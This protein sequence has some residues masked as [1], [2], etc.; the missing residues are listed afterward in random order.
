[1]IVNFNHVPKEWKKIKISEKLFFQEGPGVRKWQ[2]AKKGIKLLNV[3]NI[4]KGVVDLS[5]TD[6]NLSIEEATGKYSHFLVDEGDLLIACSGIVVDNFHNKIAFAKKEDLP[7]CLNTST[8]RFKPLNGDIDLN[9]FKYFLQTVHFSSQLQKLITGSAQ[10]NFGPSHIKKIDFL[11]PHLKIQQHI[12]GILDDAAA[13][14]DKTAQ[15]LIEYDLLAQSVF[16]EM[17]GD[18]VINEKGW[19]VKKLDNLTNLITDGKHGNCNDEDNSGYFFISAKDVKN[20]KI[21][22]L[23]TRQI[24]KKEFEEVDRRTNLQAGDLVMINTGATIGRMAIAVDIPETRKTTFQK[25]VA[26]IKTKKEVLIPLYLQYVFELRLDTF[27]NKGSGSAIKN[28]LLSEMKRF[29]IIVPPIE[30]QNE[31][32]DKIALIEQ[33]KVLAKQELQESEDLFNCLLQQAFKGELV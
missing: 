4:N 22:Y 17:F 5:T 23:N 31:F 33:Q 15:L 7:L 2:F 12:A 10:L 32:A 26:V 19:E 14:R 25:S 6:K 9:Y 13:L 16:L 28:L 8:M 24:P 11:Y 21:N 30:L 29:K 27:A 3:G 1:M 20:N 18:P